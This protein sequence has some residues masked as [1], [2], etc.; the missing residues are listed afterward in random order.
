MKT[1]RQIVESL[2][3]RGIKA[4]V[5]MPRVKLSTYTE[6]QKVGKIKREKKG[7]VI[8]PNFGT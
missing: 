4:D 5:V 7:S 6:M 3:E 8:A 1:I 2:R